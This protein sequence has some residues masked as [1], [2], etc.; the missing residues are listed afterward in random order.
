MVDLSLPMRRS[1]RPRSGGTGRWGLHQLD[2]VAAGGD[3]EG[4]GLVPV[5]AAA[6]D[7]EAVLLEAGEGGVDLGDD[8]G[9][10]RPGRDDRVV[11]V[12]QVDLGAGALEP[13]EAAVEGV[14]DLGE[15]EDREEADGAVEIGGGNLD[16]GV[17]G[18]PAGH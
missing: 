11:L 13:G 9:D 10:V 17:L 7:L 4:A 5:F 14:G 12:H 6:F 8:H 18:R 1:G 16:P 3:G 15:A 2:A